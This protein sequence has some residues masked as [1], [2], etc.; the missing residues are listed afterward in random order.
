MGPKRNHVYPCKNEF[1][2][3]THTHMKEETYK[4]DRR[5]VMTKAEAGVMQPQVKECRQP[6]KS[7]PFSPRA[8]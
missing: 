2:R 7:G 5:D 1:E 6:S 3:D 4:R 8:L